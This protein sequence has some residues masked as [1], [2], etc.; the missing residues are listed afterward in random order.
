[1]ACS[2]VLSGLALQRKENGHLFAL[3]V[4]AN[5]GG[6]SSTLSPTWNSVWFCCAA[7]D[8]VPGLSMQE[9]GPSGRGLRSC[10]KEDNGLPS[11]SPQPRFHRGLAFAAEEG[12][13]C[14]CFSL[15]V[16]MGWNLWEG[17]QSGEIQCRHGTQGHGEWLL[18]PI[19]NRKHLRVCFQPF[20]FSGAQRG[21][22]LLT[23]P[24]SR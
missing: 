10:R 13:S 22:A 17:N 21:T 4:L 7:S 15:D 2:F 23:W 14:V 18:W 24:H 3:R 8:M 5:T 9:S 19:N 11:L 16:P 6:E 12:S 1:M 20:S